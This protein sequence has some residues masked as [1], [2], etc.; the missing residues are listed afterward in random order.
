[1]AF[2]RLFVP[3]ELFLSIYLALMPWVSPG[4]AS[5]APERFRLLIVGTIGL[6]PVVG[7]WLAVRCHRQIRSQPTKFKSLY[8]AGSAIA[9]NTLG[10]AVSAFFLWA[11]RRD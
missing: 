8:F 11:M 5:L 10:L 2:G 9:F 1:M 7:L 3:K 4:V 6:A